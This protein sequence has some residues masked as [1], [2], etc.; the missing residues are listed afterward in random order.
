MSENMEVAIY[1]RKSRD[2]E[3]LGLTEVLAKHRAV[4]MGVV[5]KLRLVLVD[6][7]EE[8][9]SGESLYARPEMMKLLEAVQS[10]K[11][12]AV[13]CMDVDRLGRGGMS[14]QGIILDAFKYSGTKIITPEKTYDMADET[15]EQLLEFKTFISRQEYRIIQK[16]L[17]RGLL[18]TIRSGGYVANAPYG[19]K[20]TT[21]N[22]RPTLEIYEP[23]ARFVRM[24]FDM[25]CHGNGAHVI[26]Q[27]LNALGAVPHRSSTWSRNSVRHVLQN[28]T[29]CGK[30]VWNRKTHL[31]K[32]SRGNE[33]HITKY[34]P[35]DEWEIYDGIHEGIVSEE[36]FN[37][38]QE[39]R[40]GRTHPKYGDG[41][42][43]SSLAGLVVCS[44]CGRKMQ[45][46]GQNKGVPYLLCN[47]KGCSAGAKYEYVEESVL[48]VLKK[49]MDTLNFEL[50]VTPQSN[51]S[52]YEMQLNAVNSTLSR[53][54][55]QKEKLYELLE[56]GI[57]DVTVYRERMTFLS[58]KIDDLIKERNRLVSG[59]ASDTRKNKIILRDRI[60]A[61]LEVY[62]DASPAGR[63]SLLKDI[64]KK[65]TYTKNK[66][67]KPHDFSVELQ[68]VFDFLHSA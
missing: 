24:M 67:T 29:F 15:D 64:V 41:E 9:I 38:A 39:I 52:N 58:D 32:G 68:Y 65:I 19:Y 47:E 35:V 31:K 48:D 63:N 8:V 51:S 57:Y 37:L 26:S 34:N 62:G 4:L 60:A 11:Y 50:A 6:V 43:K 18:E 27:R 56:Q 13:L 21:I 66:K 28:P 61:S 46:M 49:Y 17:R 53:L 45:K 54:T 59:S 33:K 30:I 2:E 20:K 5:E 44:I 16:R 42:I 36:Q 12:D 10:G 14:N 25:Y 55:A 7:Y 3:N 22:R 23:E 40:L 1:L